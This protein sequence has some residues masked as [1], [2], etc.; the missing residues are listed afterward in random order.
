MSES[1]KD[2][3]LF[4]A[5][6]NQ[7]SFVGAADQL[8]LTPSAVSKGIARLE[9]RLAVKLF[10]RSTRTIKLTEPGAEFYARATSIL[11]AIEEAEAVVGNV[12]SE[13]RGDLH[14][15]SSDAFAIQVIVPMLEHFQQAY[16]RI[17]VQ[18]SQGDGPI[19]LLKEDFDVAI[20][21][22]PPGQKSLSAIPL[23]EDPWVICA[24]P[25][26]LE[27][28]AALTSPAELQHHRCLAISA[29][30]RLDNLWDFRGGKRNTITVNPVFSG[31][32][33]VVRS[34]ARRGL[35]VARLAN[36]LVREDIEK[37]NLV[38]LL[39]N[40]QLKGQR[41]IYAVAH[42]RNFV[43]AKTRLFIDALSKHI[44]AQ[45]TPAR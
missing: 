32:G 40:H 3:T 10:T 27:G 33:L 44:R 37:G 5:V 23:I 28:R 18:L 15:A 38:E 45:H 13:P 16:P 35:G 7:G 17:H 14:V 19:D 25:E 22:E 41:K 8:D 20:R 34:A 39:S 24:A 26:Y 11:D 12:A 21:F 30:G 43:P 2:L 29:R 31:I 4:C 9:D 6:V 1:L 36:F 42:E